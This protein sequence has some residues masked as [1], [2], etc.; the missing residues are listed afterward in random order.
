MEDEDLEELSLSIR[1]TVRFGSVE[2]CSCGTE[3]AAEEIGSDSEET[4]SSGVEAVSSAS[5]LSPEL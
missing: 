5:E 3:E 1:R 4:T 2:S